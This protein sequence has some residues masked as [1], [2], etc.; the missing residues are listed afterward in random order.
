MASN[1]QRNCTIPSPIDCTA[2]T[3]HGPSKDTQSHA[4]AWRD[5]QHVHQVSGACTRQ[6]HFAGIARF[7]GIDEDEI[8]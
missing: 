2:P 7:T 5:L 8:H 3:P 1:V 4:I 6:T